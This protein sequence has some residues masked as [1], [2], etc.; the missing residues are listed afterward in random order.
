M[1]QNLFF[2]LCLL[3]SIG[4]LHAQFSVSGNIKGKDNAP[5]QGCTV[6]FMQADSLIGGST[7]DKKG[8]F[9]LKEMPQGNYVCHI[10]MIGFKKIE[11]PFSLS[12]NMRLPQF[13]MEEGATQL[14][15]VTVTGDKRNDVRSGAGSATFFLSER[16]KK[17]TNAY[18]AL[19][20]IPKLIVN[21]IDRKISLNTGGTPLILING[22]NRP[23]Y[24]DALDPE[25]IESVEV[26][27]TP[28]AR[29]LGDE[30]VSCIL[31]IHLKR[32][33]TPPYFNGSIDVQPAITSKHGIS[34]ANLDLGN[35]TSSLYLNA[36]YFYYK[37]DKSDLTSNVQ[38]GNI[39]QKYSGKQLYNANSYYATLG[40]DRIFSDKNY[41]AFAVT[42]VGNPS[43]IKLEKEGS[44]E[45]LSDKKISDA[46]TYQ[47]TDNKYHTATG[48]LYYKHTFSKQQSLEATGNYA[49]S[50]SGSTGEQKERND[51]FQYNR[52]IDFSN[53]RHFGKLNLDYS[54]LINGKYNL[55]A[56]SNTSYSATNIDDLKDLF[57]L[58]TY[59]RWQEYVYVGFDNNNSGAKFNYVL[60]LGADMLFSDADR[61][62]NH[63]IDLLPAVA[64]AYK[65]NK[66][67]TLGLSYNRARF[68]P[69]ADQL[70]PRNT[71]TDS[72]FI[73]QGNPFLT[74]SIQDNVRLSYKLTY[75]KLYLEPFVYYAYSSDLISTVGTGI[76]NIYTNTYKNF[77]CANV[78][79]IGTA[80]RYNFPFGN[81]NFTASYKKKYQKDMAFS[82]DSWAA[83]I[84]G[85]FYYK[86]FSLMLNAGYETA[87]YGFTQKTENAPF[88]N[89]IFAWSL[90]KG[91][92]VKLA[93]QYYL[94]SNMS[95]KFWVRDN[96]YSSYSSHLMTDRAPMFKIGISYYFKNKVQNKW[97]E[98]KK[99]Y[100]VDKEL[101]GIS[102]K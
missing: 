3:C 87:S 6:L 86:K 61:V 66:K 68:S 70:N 48:Y 50:T 40:G 64:L 72:L 30:S 18:E 43:D 31:N 32:A 100:D 39:L 25:L 35:S 28:S 93:S 95:N 49:Y 37:D 10:S 15:E 71:S 53:N 22:I 5:L 16:A 45:Y 52:L 67:H 1:K 74:P 20:E 51:F 79:Q 91:W 58:Y 97:R 59:K 9:L 88:S 54:N 90:P 75:K 89:A 23:N 65:F 63:Y 98:K 82:G 85:Y 4:S 26:I 38:S 101:Q 29:Y 41:A 14:S 12:A 99:F 84:S 76:D 42:Y 19:V 8:D 73:Q 60:S 44:I 17:V 69:T 27:D 62:K 33:H 7:T 2:I 56:G 81:I 102:I 11:H 21:P 78:L 36:Q 77:L 24:F 80:I 96:N 13:L 46:T 34:F 47:Q 83:N 57:P 55:N 94:C 92:Q